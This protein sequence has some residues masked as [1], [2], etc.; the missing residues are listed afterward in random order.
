MDVKLHTREGPLPAS[1]RDIIIV[2]VVAWAARLLFLLIIPAAAHSFDASSWQYV[3]KLLDLGVNPYK[4]TTLL[5]WPPLWM[6][7]I[8]CIS[9]IAVFVHA[10]FFRVLQIFLMLI[11]SAVIVQLYKLIREIVPAANARNIILVG[12]ALN[13]I[14]I[15]LICQHCNFDV[16][17]ALWLILFA[18]NLIA[19]NRTNDPGHW[20]GA[21]LF[22]GLGILTKTVPLILIPMLAGGFRQVTPLLRLV[23]SFL[24]LAPVTLGMGIIYVLAPA[25]VTAKVLGYR[26]IGNN[27]SYYGIPNFLHIIRADHFQF[28]HHLMFYGLLAISIVVTW[29]LFW[30]RQPEDK[31]TVLLMAL[32]LAA[33][34][35]L[36]PGW[37]PQYIYWFLPFLVATYAFYDGEWRKVLIGF[38]V[39]VAC[40]YLIEYALISALGYNL[41]YLLDPAKA[42]G[43][44][45]QKITGFM[46]EVFQKADSRVWQTIFNL[47][48][49]IADL[50]L[51][52]FGGRILFRNIPDLLNMRV[53]KLFYSF[54][55]LAVL[56]SVIGVSIAR[57][58]TSQEPEKGNVL[59]LAIAPNLLKSGTDT[60][61]ALN[62]LAWTLATSPNPGNRDG[63]LA[64]ELAQRACEQT[65]Y[66]T[67]IML[68]T[69]A[70][71]YAEAGRFEE[72]ISTAQKACALASELGDHG[73]LYKNQ[74]LLLF[75]RAHQPYHQAVIPDSITSPGDSPTAPSS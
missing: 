3:A 19:Y 14:A 54:V 72:A 62:D 7:L 20:L 15:L 43:Q 60:A 42:L 23:G 9:K 39:I 38:G 27:I 63:G 52:I 44:D 45:S 18:R 29:N 41:L 35:T 65:H 37:G 71:A 31:E 66:Q 48:I 53:L 24:V 40:S 25:D 10:P 22:L 5:N 33:I 8:F 2:L 59:S 50:A 46:L 36:G 49:F 64:V 69:L 74:Q 75:Y 4:A 57:G 47:P 16:L 51:L 32:I 1:L 58:L 6:Q 34:S 68:G 21:C 30:R 56:G 61:I 70:A 13:P 12:I 67:P 17:V 26:A 73:Q 55:I 11:E 28:I